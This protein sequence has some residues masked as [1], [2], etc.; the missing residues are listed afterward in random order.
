[1]NFAMLW[2]VGL[3]VLS[4]IFYHICAKSSPEAVNPFAT[5][6]VTYLVGA[7]TAAIC[8]VTI[9]KGKNLAAELKQLNWAPFVLGIAIVGLEV[10]FIYLYKAGWNVSTGQMVASTVLSICLIF[11]GWF[12]YHEQLTASKLIGIA[13]CLVGL[14]FINK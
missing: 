7:I 12:L 1:M 6:I 5:L 3:I 10:G 2:P 4:N 13:I 11:V 14:Y 9:G 8:F